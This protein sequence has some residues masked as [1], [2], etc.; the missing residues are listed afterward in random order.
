MKIPNK[1][2]DPVYK[3]E[4]QSDESSRRNDGSH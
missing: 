1:N 3:A 2:L 4:K